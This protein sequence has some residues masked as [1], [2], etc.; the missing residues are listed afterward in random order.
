MFNALEILEMLEH[1]LKVMFLKSYKTK[2][3]FFSRTVPLGSKGREKGR[4]A[5]LFSD[6]ILG[7]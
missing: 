2:Q 5:C 1:Q 6:V 7:L 3:L 4:E